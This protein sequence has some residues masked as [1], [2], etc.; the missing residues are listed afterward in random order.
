MLFSCSVLSN[1]VTLSHIISQS[2][3]KLMSIKS[4]LPFNHIILCCPLLLPAVFPSIRVFSSEPALLIRW[5]KYW[6]FSFS[7]SPSNESV[8]FIYFLYDWLV[9]SPCSPRDSQESSPAP[10]FKKIN[11]LVLSLL[12][13]ST[14]TSIRDYWENH[15]F[16]YTEL[17]QQ[18]NVSAFKYIA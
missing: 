9:G 10:Q 15:S 3:L 4:V 11:S 5:P 2:L 7:I 8:Q 12:Y 17:Y 18:S 14:L 13:D 16:D 6:G 1:S